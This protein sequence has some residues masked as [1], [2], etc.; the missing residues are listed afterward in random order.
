MPVVETPDH[1]AAAER[2]TREL[3]AAYLTV[4]L[5]GRYTDAYLADAGANAPKFT[6]RI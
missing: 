5:E 3:N 4:I 6:P 2:V 1:I